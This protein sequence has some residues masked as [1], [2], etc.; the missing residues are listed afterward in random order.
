LWKALI[1]AAGLIETN[2][3]EAARPWRVIDELLDARRIDA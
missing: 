1:I 3:V 2:A